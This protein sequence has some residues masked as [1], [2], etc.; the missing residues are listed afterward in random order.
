MRRGLTLIVAGDDPQRFDAAV[1]V[2][3]AEAAIGGTVRLYAHRMAVMRL[4]DPML[5]D[6]M[7]GGVAVIAC[8]TGLA[9]AGIDLSTLDPRI[10]GGGMVGLLLA[11]G[12][13][14]LVLV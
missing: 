2:A 10:E 6:A 1:A 11:L 14:R 3:A 8:Q 5:V 4:S 7:D 12:D 13:D 9:E